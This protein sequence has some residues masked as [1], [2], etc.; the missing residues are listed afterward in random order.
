[1]PYL[2]FNLWPN[3]I[4]QISLLS[5]ASCLVGAQKEQKSWMNQSQ[6]K[7]N[8]KNVQDSVC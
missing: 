6:L 7:V 2:N 5:G 1:M 4:N 8:S 3:S